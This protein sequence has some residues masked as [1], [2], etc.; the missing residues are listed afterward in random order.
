MNVWLGTEPFHV[1]YTLSF[2][3]EAFEHY[4]YR[5]RLRSEG[6]NPRE[7]IKNEDTI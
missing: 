2:F 1:Y 3:H 6:N 5:I 4:I 7:T